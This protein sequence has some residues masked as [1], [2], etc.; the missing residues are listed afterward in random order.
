MRQCPKVYDLLPLV[1]Q[2]NETTTMVSIS[3]G[4]HSVAWVPCRGINFSS[5]PTRLKAAWLV[6][7]GKADAVVWPG[8]Q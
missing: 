4:P 1:K 8:D 6:F 7:T 3:T 2:V 5:I